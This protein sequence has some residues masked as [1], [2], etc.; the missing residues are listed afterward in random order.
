VNTVF[1]LSVR[2]DGKVYKLGSVAA[3]K[4]ADALQ[5]CRERWNVCWFWWTSSYVA[6]GDGIEY[7]IK[8]HKPKTE[9]NYAS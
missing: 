2:Q 6:E 7:K 8:E 9:D 4:P 5:V 3:R 1:D